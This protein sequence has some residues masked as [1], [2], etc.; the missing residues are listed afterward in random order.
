MFTTAIEISRGNQPVQSAGEYGCLNIREILKALER[1]TPNQTV[2]MRLAKDGS[3]TP[4]IVVA[5]VPTIKL[6]SGSD[7]AIRC[8]F[9]HLDKHIGHLPA[10]LLQRFCEVEMAD[11]FRPTCNINDKW[12][13]SMH[14]WQATPE[15]N[16]LTFGGNNPSHRVE[17]IFILPE[18][19]MVDSLPKLN[20]MDVYNKLKPYKSSDHIAVMLLR[21]SRGEEGE[22]AGKLLLGVGNV[23]R[24]KAGKETRNKMGVEIELRHQDMK[25]IEFD[26]GRGIFHKGCLSFIDY[27]TWGLVFC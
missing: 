23:F 9:T 26:R 2:I 20:P 10:Y 21:T 4:E 14:I 6:P 24:V 11:S 5:Q 17:S 3:N 1:V 12:R 25:F 19:D 8:T 22:E 16:E 18:P 7:S 27:W 13:D 15:Y